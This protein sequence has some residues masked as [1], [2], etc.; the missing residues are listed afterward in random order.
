MIFW[1]HNYN[2]YGRQHDTIATGLLTGV[3]LVENCDIMDL[4]VTNG[5]DLCRVSS[6]NKIE[7]RKFNF[8]H[9]LV[10][11]VGDNFGRCFR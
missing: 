10:Q 6:K 9:R 1:R 5:A 4:H 8:Y 7:R 3:M 2:E 11:D